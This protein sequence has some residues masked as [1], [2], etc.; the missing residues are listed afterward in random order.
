MYEVIDVPKKIIEIPIEFLP[1]F[2][3]DPIS[4]YQSYGC[5][6]RESEFPYFNDRHA[7]HACIDKSRKNPL[8]DNLEFDSDF[9]CRD[10]NYRFMHIDL[11]H[12]RDACGISMCYVS[13]WI[14]I[15]V[16]NE[17]DGRIQIAEDMAPVFTFDFIY[18][19]AA[20]K[21][22]EIKFENVRKIIYDITRRDFNLLLIT[23]DRFQSVD[24]IQIL[25]DHGYVVANLSMDKTTK[26]PI[27]DID[28]EERFSYKQVTPG[29]LTPI[30]AWDFGKRALSQGRL[31]IPFYLPVSDIEVWNYD[32]FEG[33]VD[34]FGNKVPDSGSITWIEREMLA[35]TYDA[36]LC[37]VKEPPKGTIDLLESVV[38]SAF[39]AS[40]NVTVNPEVREPVEYNPNKRVYDDAPVIKRELSD[41]E[42][43]ERAD[44]FTDEDDIYGGES[45]Y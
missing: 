32:T 33:N 41:R 22:D 26:Y 5:W 16:R 31:R 42:L 36:K 7:V 29:K 30:T 4:A 40:N 37:K 15:Q 35:A 11:G 27:I 17:V 39:N 19:M 18:R 24:M 14:P 6:P 20:S 43:R 25:R 44:Q 38:G 1:D 23:F 13:D 34:D 3:G 12:T 9:V 2:L 28:A 45:L 8:N 21:G 10:D